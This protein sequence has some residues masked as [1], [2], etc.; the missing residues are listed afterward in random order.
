MW[1]GLPDSVWPSH[2][3]CLCYDRLLKAANRRIHRAGAQKASARC[4]FLYRKSLSGSHA[5]EHAGSLQGRIRPTLCPRGPQGGQGTL[6]SQPALVPACTFPPRALR[7]PVASVC[8]CSHYVGAGFTVSAVLTTSCCFFLCLDLNL[9]GTWEQRAMDPKPALL[10]YSS[11]YLLS[12][13][14]QF[15][16][17]GE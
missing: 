2:T 3:Q 17:K 12:S 11:V 9:D 16:K 8:S 4:F 5:S 6:G 15:S 7:S 13:Q 10:I 14:Q 1:K